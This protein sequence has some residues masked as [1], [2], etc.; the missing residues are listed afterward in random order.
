MID[1]VRH[2]RLVGLLPLLVGAI[3]GTCSAVG[4]AQPS[5][6]PPPVTVSNTN[7][8]TVSTASAL[9]SDHSYK[10]TVR[11]TVSDWPVGAEYPQVS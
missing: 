6:A 1:R 11:G 9:E 10:I 2:R 4:S 7:P 8:N 5:G 3:V